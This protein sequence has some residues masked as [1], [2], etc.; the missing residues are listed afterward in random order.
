M[1]QCLQKQSYQNRLIA[2]TN[3]GNP[4]YCLLGKAFGIKSLYL[5]CQEHLQ[6]M[7]HKFLFEDM[8]IPVLFHVKIKKTSCLPMVPP[9]NSISNMIL[10]D[11]THQSNENK[12]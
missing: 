8:D 11:E 10:D 4:D 6:K 3:T 1:V 5:D 2:V 9:G 7:M 12:P